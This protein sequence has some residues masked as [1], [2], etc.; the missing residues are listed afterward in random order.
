M[1]W[2]QQRFG[3]KADAQ[4]EGS[5]QVARWLSQYIRPWSTRVLE[6]MSRPHERRME[7][8]EVCPTELEVS[9]VKLGNGEITEDLWEMANED[10]LRAGKDRRRREPLVKVID[11]YVVPTEQPV[12]DG[13]H[14]TPGSLVRPL[15][16]D[17]TRRGAAPGTQKPRRSAF[18]K[19]S[20][21]G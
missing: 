15:R 8:Q 9:V 3:G 21:E 5:T 6:R 2:Q 20:E 19:Q 17:G 1:P 13:V 12:S 4:V 16:P 7:Q 10:E 11:S 14:L 18:L